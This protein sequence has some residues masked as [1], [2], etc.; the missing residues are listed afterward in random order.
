MLSHR[1]KAV[2]S[3][4]AATLDSVETH[5][6]TKIGDCYWSLA[7]NWFTTLF[8]S[9][10]TC[11]AGFNL[12][13]LLPLKQM[14]HSQTAT[15]L[16]SVKRL[17]SFDPTSHFDLRL[18]LWS[19]KHQ[20]SHLSVGLFWQITSKHTQPDTKFQCDRLVNDV[21]KPLTLHQIPP[22]CYNPLRLIQTQDSPLAWKKQWS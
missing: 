21:K 12:S 4:T 9:Y 16:N 13:G 11:T 15:V 19:R 8:V 18:S 3:F 22:F 1:Q 10:F 2:N 7:K 6:C 20:I 17:M 5:F 14:K